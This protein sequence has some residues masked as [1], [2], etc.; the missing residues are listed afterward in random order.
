MIS[1]FIQRSGGDRRET[2]VDRRLRLSSSRW[3]VAHF[4]MNIYITTILLISGL[5]IIGYLTH[6]RWMYTWGET[7]MGMNTS[8]LFLLIGIVLFSFNNISHAPHD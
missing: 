2:G 1:R 6:Q 4:I 5:S 3:V 8:F 7:P